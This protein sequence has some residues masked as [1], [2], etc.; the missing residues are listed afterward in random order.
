MKKPYK[1]GGAF[2]CGLKFLCSFIT[3]LNRA[4]AG[5]WLLDCPRKNILNLLRRGRR[6]NK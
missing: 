5:F 4:G 6:S 2:D 1:G 3:V